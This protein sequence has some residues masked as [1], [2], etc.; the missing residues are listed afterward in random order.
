MKK[1]SKRMPSVGAWEC[2]WPGRCNTIL[3]LLVVAGMAANGE[4]WE[5]GT[6]DPLGG[7]YSS[8]Q[9]DTLGKACFSTASGITS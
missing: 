5:T 3:I 6:V 2:G 9:F 1:N 4:I 8:L 7:D